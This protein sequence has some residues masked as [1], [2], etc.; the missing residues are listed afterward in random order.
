MNKT[1]LKSVSAPATNCL[2]KPWYGLVEKISKCR[3]GIF[4]ATVAKL[5][6]L[7]KRASLNVLLT[8]SFL[9]TRVKE[10]DVIDWNKLI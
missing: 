6:F 2:L 8:I 7:A 3:A 4:H 1:K 9:S 10:P 5:L